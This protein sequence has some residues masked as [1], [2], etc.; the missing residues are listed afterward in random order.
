MVHYVT[1][2]TSLAICWLSSLHMW[3]STVFTVCES[4]SSHWFSSV[5]CNILLFMPF[6]ALDTLLSS[7]VSMSA[8]R[9]VYASTLLAQANTYSQVISLV[10]LTV[11][12][13][14]MIPVSIF[15][16]IYPLISCPFSLL[17]FSLYSHSFAIILRWSIH[18]SA[19]SLCCLIVFMT[20]RF[21]WVHQ[22][23][24]CWLYIFLVLVI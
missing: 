4:F 22:I 6:M 9:T 18:S 24:P 12:I 21:H 14:H 3:D 23:A 7:M 8:F 13:S 2:W 17:S 5:K 20:Y 1:S 11:V 10:F 19:F 16:I 15:V